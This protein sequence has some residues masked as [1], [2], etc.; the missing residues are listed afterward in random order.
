VCIRRIDMVLNDGEWPSCERSGEP[1]G[2][3]QARKCHTET[4]AN[5]GVWL[6]AS[7]N[8]KFATYFPP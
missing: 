5:L 7:A 6:D 4:V 2:G 8:I 1:S 3:K